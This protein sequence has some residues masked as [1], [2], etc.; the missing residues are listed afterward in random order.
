MFV[1]INVFSFTTIVAADPTKIAIAQLPDLDGTKTIIF[2]VRSQSDY[3]E[4]HIKGALWADRKEDYRLDLC[5]NYLVNHPYQ[6][7]VI[8]YSGLDKKVYSDGR[9]AS[10]AGWFASD[11]ATWVSNGGQHSQLPPPLEEVQWLLDKEFDFYFVSEDPF[12][13][14]GWLDQHTEWAVSGSGNIDT[15]TTSIRTPPDMDGNMFVVVLAIPII[16]GAFFGYRYIADRFT[17]NT[18]KN[19]DEHQEKT[20]SK[21]KQILNDMSSTIDNIPKEKSEFKLRRR[22]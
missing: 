6:G 10:I 16:V 8:F 7:K 19:L 4:R 17:D 13:E 5:N 1:L 20:L 9:I 15:A 21:R 18:I 2:D 22:K 3:I 14:G 11:V 12:A